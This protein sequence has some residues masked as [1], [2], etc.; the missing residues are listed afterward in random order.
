MLITYFRENTSL[1]HNSP[2]KQ[3]LEPPFIL[4]CP[5]PIPQELFSS[6][7]RHSLDPEEISVV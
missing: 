7:E 6:L 1:T 5:P 3:G 2:T 4:G